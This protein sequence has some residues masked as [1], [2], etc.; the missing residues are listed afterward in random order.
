MYSIYKD[1]ETLKK[2]L[3]KAKKEYKDSIR[4]RDYQDELFK[5]E[6]KDSFDLDYLDYLVQRRKIFQ[7]RIGLLESLFGKHLDNE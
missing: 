3:G 5:K 1:S 6:H 4:G 7:D 2:I